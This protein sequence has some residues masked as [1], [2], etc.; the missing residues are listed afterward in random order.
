MYVESR[1]TVLMNLSQRRKKRFRERT[2]GHSRGRRGWKRESSTDTHR[3]SCVK[4]IASEKLLRSTG[5]PARHCDDLKGG[6]EAEGRL[7]RK[8]ICVYNYD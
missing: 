4:Q 8:K 2:G 7:Q 6:M 1:K 5:S 3:P